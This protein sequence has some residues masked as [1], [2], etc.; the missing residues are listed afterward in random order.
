MKFFPGARI[1]SLL[2]MQIFLLFIGVLGRD[3]HLRHNTLSK[4]SPKSR[5]RQCHCTL[6]LARVP[7]F[8]TFVS[9][10]GGAP[11]PRFEFKRRR[12][13]RKKSA[14][15]SGR[16]LAI[17]G[18]FFWSEVNICP[19]YVRSNVKFS[20]SDKFSTLHAYISKLI[21]RSDLKVSPTCFSLNS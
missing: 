16:V 10:G 2:E 20:Q 13:Q 8:T 21:K 9:V 11:H 12:A 19:S 1:M 4:Y 7:Y 14:G 3:D 6:T 5:A 15:C 17:C 18:A